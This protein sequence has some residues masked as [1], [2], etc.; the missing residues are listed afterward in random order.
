MDKKD[1]LRIITTCAKKYDENLEGNNLLII[2]LSNKALNHIEIKFLGS[3]FLHLTGVS[4]KLKASSFYN[5]C[6]NGKLSID[7]FGIKTDGTT[8]LK[9]TILP[10]LMDLCKNTNIIGQYNGSK[11]KL[12]TDKLAGNI[13]GCMGLIKQGQYYVPN[14]ALKEDIRDYIFKSEKVIAI[15]GKS[16][17]DKLYNRLLYVSKEPEINITSEII[18]KIDIDNF[19]VGFNQDNPLIAHLKVTGTD[20]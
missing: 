8:V 14:T 2:S 19:I 10:K 16:F 4:T 20:D 13:V 5:K 18:S 6:I 15:F 11:V 9:L 1:A 3:N 17:S 12:C 7:D